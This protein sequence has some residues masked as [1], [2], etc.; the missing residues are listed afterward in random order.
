MPL[1]LIKASVIAKIPPATAINGIALI[2]VLNA[3]LEAAAACWDK[4]ILVVVVVAVFVAI[5]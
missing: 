4:L 2:A 5:L 1:D 3:K